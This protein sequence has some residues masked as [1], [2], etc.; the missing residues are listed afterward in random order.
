M[1]EQQ[2][3]NTVWIA[4]ALMLAAALTGSGNRYRRVWATGIAT[5][6]LAATA[7]FVP[8]ITGPLAIILALGMF[9]EVFSGGSL[10]GKAL[11]T[12]GG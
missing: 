1:S 8:Q 12:Q 4:G 7:E 5:V 3:R 10:L 11:G 9:Y 2:A 6:I